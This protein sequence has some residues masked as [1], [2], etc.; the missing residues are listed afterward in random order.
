VRPGHTVCITVAIDASAA[1]FAIGLTT[2]Q[3][4]AVA[5]EEFVFRKEHPC[6]P[7][8]N[9]LRVNT[10]STRQR[11]MKR[12]RTIIAKRRT[13]TIMATMKKRKIT[14]IQRRAI[15]RMR[16]GTVKLRISIRRNNKTVAA[17]RRVSPPDAQ[18]FN[19]RRCVNGGDSHDDGIATIGTE[20][21]GEWQSR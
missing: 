19:S 12:P 17:K 6:R 20:D 18:L 9:T 3:E 11:N 5:V 10:T 4:F 16:I 1:D 2:A 8:R 21:I 7:K 14:P 13:I 15:V